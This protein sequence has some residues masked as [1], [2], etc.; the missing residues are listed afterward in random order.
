M[1]N[2]YEKLQLNYYLKEL[3]GIV[4][5]TITSMLKISLLMSQTFLFSVRYWERGRFLFTY[6]QHWTIALPFSCKHSSNSQNG[7]IWLNYPVTS[8]G[9]YVLIF[10]SFFQND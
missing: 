4:A 2:K 3:E 10:R 8:Y 6:H 9:F 5:Y 7:V 1:E